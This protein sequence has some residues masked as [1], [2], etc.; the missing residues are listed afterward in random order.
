M[1]VVWL[2]GR[3]RRRYEKA[4]ALVVQ[5]YWIINDASVQVA[6]ECFSIALDANDNN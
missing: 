4:L 6:F 5:S 1:I 3:D 2:G